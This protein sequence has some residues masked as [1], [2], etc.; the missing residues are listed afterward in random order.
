M[1]NLLPLAATF[2]FVLPPAQAQ[3]Q[4]TSLC[5]ATQKAAVVVRAT[6]VAATDPSPLW[7]RLQLH[8]DEL[9]H[10]TIDADFTLVEPAGACCGRSL[11]ALEIGERCLLMLEW[12]GPA[13]HVFGGSRGVL[14]DDPAIV[15][16]VRA[17]LAA[18]DDAQRA[19]LL[20]ASLTAAQPRIA[21]DAACAL[22]ALPQLALS[23]AGRAAVV[24]AL[25]GDVLRGATRAAPLVDV[26]VRLHDATMLDAVLPT[27]LGTAR[28]DQAALLRR[29]LSRCDAPLVIDRMMLAVDG[30][31]TKQ[32][33]AAQLLATLP[34]DQ[35][36]VGMQQML[37]RTTNPRV[38]FHLAEGMLA[39]GVPGQA[40]AAQMPASMQLPVLRL[41]QQR[42]DR[43][44]TFRSID[45]L[46]R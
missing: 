6:V 40:V 46:R 38:L 44:K 37:A 23:A 20:A 34:P 12:R 28:A 5:A 32:V 26:V 18:T 31:E 11:F 16:H 10:G 39:I 30:S 27:Y 8:G 24:S 7:H 3:D 29:G 2:A 42:H 4:A 25:H 36:R 19:A 15:A 35:A 17:L 21:D 1:K 41:A 22:A 43:A 14:P 9:L 45:P 33:R 13:L